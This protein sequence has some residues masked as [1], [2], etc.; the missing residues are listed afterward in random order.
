M[1][2]SI[3]RGHRCLVQPLI[4]VSFYLPNGKSKYCTCKWRVCGDFELRMQDLGKERQDRCIG[5][6]VIGVLSE[7]KREIV[8]CVLAVS[9]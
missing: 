1:I 7:V 6:C 3:I 2:T 9:C 4:S 8:C 5:E